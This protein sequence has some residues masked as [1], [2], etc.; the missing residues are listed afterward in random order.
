[1]IGVGELEMVVRGASYPR[2]KNDL[3][4]TPAETTR[5][6]LDLVKFGAR[7]CDPACGKNAIVKV[8][9]E[10]GYD[11]DGSDIRHRY[12]FL[13]DEFLWPE[14]DI[15]SNPPYGAGGRVAMAFIKRAL[16]VTAPWQGKV[17]MLLH[18]DFDS[19]K[20]RVP[21]FRDCPAFALKIV[22]L[23]RIRWFHGKS[24]AVNHCWAIWSH[25]HRGPPIIRYAEQVY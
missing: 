3:Y 8:L 1:M 14:Y 16:E 6:L 19:G 15:I 5:V 9:R 2:K 20:T 12:D 7:V 4:E 13:K 24:G 22:L 21:L 10:R 25:K 17:A 23:N 11:V 18:A